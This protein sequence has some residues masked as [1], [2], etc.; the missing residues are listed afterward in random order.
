MFPGLQSH[1][2]RL[3]SV[4]IILQFVKRNTDMA[5][6]NGAAGASAKTLKMEN[7]R[8]LLRFTSPD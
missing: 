4:N 3:Q 8:D 6:A 1:R 7:V 5:V 2:S